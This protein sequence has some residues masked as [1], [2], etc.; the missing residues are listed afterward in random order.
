M[1]FAFLTLF[2]APFIT[3]AVGAAV[4]PIAEGI[5]KRGCSPIGGYWSPGKSC[6][7]CCEG[8][9]C[10]ASSTWTGQCAVRCL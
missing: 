7:T 2:V 4:S 1:R 5:A 8:L 3:A 10:V 9:T 6:M